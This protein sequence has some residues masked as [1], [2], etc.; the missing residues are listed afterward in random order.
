L[1]VEE[2]GGNHEDVFVMA[3]E[4]LIKK[5]LKEVQIPVFVRVKF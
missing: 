2:R 5:V 3:D 4:D 1:L